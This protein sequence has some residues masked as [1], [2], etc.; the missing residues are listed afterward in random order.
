MPRGQARKLFAW[1]VVDRARS[2]TG[3]SIHA[4]LNAV[5]TTAGPI[6][7]RLKEHNGGQDPFAPHCA[8]WSPDLK[9]WTSDCTG[10]VCWCLGL[11]RYQP[12]DW[13]NTD[14]ALEDALKKKVRF[15]PLEL[16]ELGCVVVYGGAWK[17]G[18]RTKVG[19]WGIVTGLPAEW[20]PSWDLLSVTHCSSG[21]S[22][23]HGAAIAET[24]GQL[25]AR[26]GRFL[27]YR[28]LA[29]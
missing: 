1:Q 11:D 5:G 15:E 23:K 29:T 3:K 9:R 4:P 25:W 24:S 17:N 22:R 13:I 2:L 12:P 20:G 28:G 18:I 7:Y 21:Q 10:F 8:S 14:S 27:R 16:P 19:H 26:H 6:L